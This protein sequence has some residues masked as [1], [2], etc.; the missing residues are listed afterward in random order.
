MT[1]WELLSPGRYQVANVIVAKDG[2]RWRIDLPHGARWVKTR[3]EA[4][5]IAEYY[6][7]QVKR[8]S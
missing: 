1:G 7:R 8:E 6:V 4:L 5:A 3:G 2:K